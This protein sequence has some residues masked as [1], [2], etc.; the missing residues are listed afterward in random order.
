MPYKL[1][2]Q[3]R[4]RYSSCTFNTACSVEPLNFELSHGSFPIGLLMEGRDER[5]EENRVLPA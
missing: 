4:V 5:I 1:S 3:A 2:E